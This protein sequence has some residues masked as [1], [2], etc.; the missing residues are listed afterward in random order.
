MLRFLAGR[1]A[2]SIPTLL[3]IATLAFAMLHAA[4]GGPFDADKQMLPEIKA[5]IERQYHLDEPVWRQY[6]RYLSDLARGDLGPSYQYRS[7]RVTEML[8]QGLPVDLAVGGSALFLA[9]VLGGAIGVL[10]ALRRNSVWDHLLMA[11]AVLGLSV[12]VFVIAPVLV[13]VFA[14]WLQWLPPG[15][16]GGFS[17]L[18]LPAVA[19]AFPHT[20]YIARL[21]RASM[22]EVLAAPYIRT[23]RAKGLPEYQIALRHALKPALLPLVSYLGPAIAGVITGSIVIE[24]VFGLPGIGRYF[25]TGALNRDYT[26]V[27]GITLLYGALII[28][29]NLFVDLCYAWLDPRVRHDR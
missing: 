14:I 16:W 17:K 6:L 5:S 26:L 21:M 20:A 11:V 10:A 8:A 12:P 22:L 23:A 29:C 13:L 24:S 15:D 25:T 27:M 1:L 18:I 3:L 19:L 2:S 7:T 9:L 4:P 28:V